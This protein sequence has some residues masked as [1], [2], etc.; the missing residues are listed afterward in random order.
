[1]TAINTEDVE[2]EGL[3]R[4]ALVRLIQAQ[5]ER[6][7]SLHAKLEKIEAE[8][9]NRIDENQKRILIVLD[10]DPKTDSVGIRDRVKAIEKVIE[11]WQQYKLLVRGI[12]IGM[13]L[14][15]VM[16]GAN[17]VTLLSILSGKTP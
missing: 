8:R 4:M 1:M 14:T 13:G 6:I 7:N 11:E 5:N 2:L 15:T 12:S 9:I 17:L 3:D 16:S 10:G